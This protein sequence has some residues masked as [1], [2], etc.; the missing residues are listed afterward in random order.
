ML[1]GKRDGDKR[2]GK[3]G[4]EVYGDESRVYNVFI[5]NHYI[6]FL[7]LYNFTLNYNSSFVS[8]YI[9]FPFKYSGFHQNFKLNKRFNVSKNIFSYIPPKKK[10]TPTL[11]YSRNCEDAQAPDIAFIK[12]P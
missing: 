7:I 3:L 8:E 5:A 1:S 12:S 4:D 11:K 9:F 10:K 6:E 2:P